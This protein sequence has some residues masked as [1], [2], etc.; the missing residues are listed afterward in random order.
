LGWLFLEAP[1]I[2]PFGIP[3]YRRRSKLPRLA[4]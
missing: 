4:T 2:K 3:P 1:S